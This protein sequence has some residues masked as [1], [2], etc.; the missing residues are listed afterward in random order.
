MESPQ[1]PWLAL[2]AFSTECGFFSWVYKLLPV[3]LWTPYAGLGVGNVSTLGQTCVVTPF[4]R[5]CFDVN[6]F[7]VLICFKVEVIPCSTSCTCFIYELRRGGG[8]SSYYSLPVPLSL[9]YLS[10]TRLLLHV[11]LLA[12]SLAC[13][14]R[15]ARSPRL[16]IQCGEVKKKKN[17]PVSSK[18]GMESFWMPQYQFS[19]GIPN[20]PNQMLTFPDVKSSSGLHWK[21]FYFST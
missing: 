5:W 18:R 11:L 15:P 2:L 6:G 4:A 13:L 16:K 12:H 10:V 17:V 20:K 21:I 9:L 8:C 1:P 7:T 3:V 19:T 14:L